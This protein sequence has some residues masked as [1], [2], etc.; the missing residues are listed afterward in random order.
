MKL[1][2]LLRANFVL[3]RGSISKVMA[4]ENCVTVSA[5]YD[6]TLQVW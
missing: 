5:S 6:C 1:R 2:R 4:D 3:Y